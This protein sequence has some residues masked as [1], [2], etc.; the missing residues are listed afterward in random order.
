MPYKDPDT[1]RTYDRVYK[2]QEREA[3]ASATHPTPRLSPEFEEVRLGAAV[4]IL[5]VL[6]EQIRL[7]REAE[8]KPHET[9]KVIGYLCSVALRAIETV[10]VS[11]RVTAIEHVLRSRR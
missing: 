8:D 7:L 11:E 2:R 6:A 5:A 9:A 3:N 1:R 4:D 10:Q